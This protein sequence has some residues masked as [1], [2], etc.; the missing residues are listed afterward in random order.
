MRSGA[1]VRGG[2]IGLKF[3]IDE[4]SNQQIA[5][6]VSKKVSKIAV[7]RNRIRRRVYAVIRA[8]RDNLPNGFKG[9]FTVFDVSYKNRS[10][11]DVEQDVT[12]L[13]KRIKS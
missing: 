11:Q 12:S 4:A 8:D 9:V 10:I 7:T 13:I 2:S 1:S 6:V 3:R 5:V